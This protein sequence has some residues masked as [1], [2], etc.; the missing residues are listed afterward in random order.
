MSEPLQTGDLAAK[1]AAV[2]SE[3]VPTSRV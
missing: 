2:P 3:D 1:F